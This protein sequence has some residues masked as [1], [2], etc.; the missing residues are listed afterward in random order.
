MNIK[1]G[2]IFV[3]V[4]LSF[5][6]ANVNAQQ[7]KF[8]AADDSIATEICVLAGSNEKAKLRNRI[9]KLGSSKFKTINSF[10]CND[11]S[12]SN[13]ANQYDAT[14]SLKYIN[15]YSHKT[16]IAQPSVTIKDLAMTPADN[17]LEPITIY[18]TTAH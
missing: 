16:N 5:V 13:F 3:S 12:M 2:L 1:K 11:M 10:R 4:A 8:V 6:A 15:R 14:D 9:A 17:S 7:Y 18:V